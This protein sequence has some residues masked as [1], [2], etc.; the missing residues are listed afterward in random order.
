ML[1]LHNIVA[2]PLTKE[3]HR[4]DHRQS[5][6]GGASIEQFSEVPPGVVVSVQLHLLNDLGN[7]ELHNWCVDVA[8]SVVSSEYLHGFLSSIVCNQPSRAL[9]EEQN[10]AHG[11]RWK[12]ALHQSWCA[13]SPAVLEMQVR[14]VRGPPSEDVPKPPVLSVSCCI[15]NF[16]PSRNTHQKLLYIPAWKPRNEGCASSTM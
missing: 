1:L 12:E 10:E 2:T 14:P 7:L 5:I 3:G 15:S 9:G 11:D 16:Q 8:I 4:N 13:P 6:T